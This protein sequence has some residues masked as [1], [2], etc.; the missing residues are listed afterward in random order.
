MSNIRA[1]L[2]N[3]ELA[4]AAYADLY[5]G[6]NNS[7]YEIALENNGDGMSPTQAKDFADNWRVLDQYDGKVEET[8]TDEFGQEHTFLNPTGLSVTAFE[9]VK[10]GEQ[11]VAV[12]G[13]EP[14][15]IDDILTDIIDIGVLGTADKQAQYAALSAKVQE[16]LGSGTLQT[17]FNVTGH[18]LG[19]FLATNL[20]IDY[21]TDI[22]HTYLYNA[23]GVTGVVKGILQTINN[24]LTPD[25]PMAI[26]NVLPISNIIATGDVVSSVG[27]YI[28]PPLLMSVETRSPL[29][30]H[31]MLRVTDALAIYNLF[32]AIDANATLSDLTPIL[33]AA[34]NQ[35]NE[36][37]ET[38]VHAL[39]ELLMESI[40]VST[41]DR[42]ALY[43]AIHAI[44][45]E[46]LVDRTAADPQL[47]P[48][49]QNLNVIS[50][51]NL[52]QAQIVENANSDIG[53]R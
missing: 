42:E 23:P 29:G 35:G 25:N 37:L 48:I 1:Y 4:L 6:M 28:A 49:Y 20:A 26:P 41:D 12:R 36:T 46:L 47:N 15:D 31:S 53:Y 17:G 22:A 21:S 5:A 33:D 19:G 3:A 52:T 34:S 18:S 27:M 39:S 2:N 7:D 45:T 51:P 9:N 8:Y 50:L 30:A 40:E 38:M 44:E 14:T 32:S 43:Q 16:W 10:T 11:V 24:A 13:T